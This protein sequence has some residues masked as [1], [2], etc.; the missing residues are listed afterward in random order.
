MHRKLKQKKEKTRKAFFKTVPVP[1]KKIPQKIKKK[2]KGEKVYEN[3]MEIKLAE[4]KNV[5]KILEIIKN[6]CD[7]FEK[8]Y[9]EQ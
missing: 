3:K 5:S 9:I 8:N 6:R 1:T 2:I 7:W 4:K